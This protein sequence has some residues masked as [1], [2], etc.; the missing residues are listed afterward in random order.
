MLCR[1]LRSRRQLR[2]LHELSGGHRLLWYWSL[3]VHCRLYNLRGWV[4]WKCNEP[5]IRRGRWL[6]NLLGWQLFICRCCK[7]HELLGRHLLI[8]GRFEL[9]E[10]PRGHHHI[11]CRALHVRGRLHGLRGRLRRHRLQLRHDDRQLPTMCGRYLLVRGRLKL[12][13]LRGRFLLVCGRYELHELC[14]RLLRLSERLELHFVSVW[15]FHNGLDRRYVSHLMHNVRARLLRNGH[16]PR[17]VDC[18]RLHAVPKGCVYD[19]RR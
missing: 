11:R 19:G 9:H 4:L 8:C 5:W 3:Y 15:H 1:H 14:G 12:H 17:L 13:E 2:E 10:L 18:C 16:K 7:L 6:L